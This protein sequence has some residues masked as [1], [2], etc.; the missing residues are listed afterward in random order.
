MNNINSLPPFKRF[1]VTIGN[2]PS[3][4]VDSMSYYE[5]LM[6]LCKYLKDTVIPALNENAEAVNELIN[7]FNNLDVTE[8]VNAKLDSMV[9]DGSLESMMKPY[10]D[11]YI[12]PQIDTLNTNFN[13][14][15]DN[16]ESQLSG[17]NSNIDN[18]EDNIENQI[19][20]VNTR[21]D[22]IASGSPAGVYP[23]VSDLTTADPDHDKIY[24]ISATGHWYYYDSANNQWSD[25]GVYQTSLI[26]NNK[27]TY[28]NLKQDLQDSLK[29]VYSNLNVSIQD[30]KILD[31]D[32]T[33]TTVSD[34][35]LGVASATITGGESIHILTGIYKALYGNNYCL[36]SFFDSSN[37]VISF[38]LNNDNG[39]VEKV[40]VAPENATKINVQY[41]IGTQLAI[42]ADVKFKP[43]E[44]VEYNDLEN[45]LKNVFNLAY[46]TSI[47]PSE[48]EIPNC[49]IYIDDAGRFVYSALSGYNYKKYQLK[50]NTNYKLKKAIKLY[51]NVIYGFTSNV[52][53]TITISGES[54]LVNQLCDVYVG[55]G[56]EA[57]IDDIEFVS[58]SY[59]VYLYVLT[60]NTN[61][62]VVEL[63]EGS[64]L[65]VE[66]SDNP[67][68]NKKVGFVGDSIC[69]ATTEGVKGWATL[70][71]ENEGC[72]TYNYGV[73]GYRIGYGTTSY[74]NTHS[75]QTQLAELI[76]DHSDLD[77]ILIQGG[78][79]DYWSLAGDNPIQ[80]GS[81]DYTSFSN[82]DKNTF[83]G[84]LEYMFNY[85]KTNIPNAKL[86]YIVT[87]KVK[88]TNLFENSSF[89]SY[90]NE[91]IEVCKKWSVPYIDLMNEG[92]I[93]G[94]ITVDQNR[95]FIPDRENPSVGD[96]CHPNLAGY[97]VE[98]NIIGKYLKY[99]I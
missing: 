93:N 32:G 98:T 92:I 34:T 27:V 16:I 86:I 52:E 71:S 1:C 62:D 24:L 37:N 53:K 91:A 15:E 76:S 4:Y 12:Q 56:G 74:S 22:S 99:H 5:C 66:S 78:V 21:I 87:H 41:T 75:I 38:G 61:E 13:E 17:I 42:S 94:F 67:L 6:W 96:G 83:L 47:D 29:S 28:T 85:C 72:T 49:V 43:K 8:E 9:E 44:K 63:L 33:I 45:K 3:S 77:Y 84:G 89:Y 2:L 20:N 80:K 88:N 59:A 68:I 31:T 60:S 95:Y 97:T 11:T 10:L 18:I 54:Y 36:Y 50:P 48:N 82:Y 46:S 30:K 51:N 35:R 7:W 25:G 58:P 64:T 19:S 26:G 55:S 57:I 81:I 73:D 90:E 69:A 70:L 40:V 14:L 65:Y 39:N 23:T 79:N